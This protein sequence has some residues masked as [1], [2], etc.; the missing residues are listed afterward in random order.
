MDP[1]SK[2]APRL[3]LARPAGTGPGDGGDATDSEAD[4]G[5]LDSFHRGEAR[6]IEGC[7]RRYFTTI[8]RAIGSLLGPADR[9]TVI[10]ELFSRLIADEA[11]R[12]SFQPVREGS[13]PAWLARV[14]RNRAIDFRRRLAREATLP[15]NILASGA[16]AGAG[17]GH[18]GGTGEWSGSIDAR[19]LVEQFRRE[20]VPLAWDGVFEMRF[21]RRLSQREAAR[22][23]GMHR[24][25]LAY[26]ELRIRRRLRRFIL[27]GEE[28]DQG[29]DEDDHG[30][31]D[32]DHTR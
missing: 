17:G 25:T 6:A 19:L 2:A 14:A 18:P 32:D 26:R 22:T 9:E 31:T 12:R 5:W 16:E 10:H 23:L 8:K 29:H 30:A 13:L 27:D 4:P 3:R 11:L 28:Q 24:T 20:H 15:G 21:L 7:Y 1:V